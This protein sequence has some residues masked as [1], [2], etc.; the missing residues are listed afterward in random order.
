MSDK[1]T[2]KQQAF[3]LEYLLDFNATAAAER[4]GYR[5]SRQVLA[6][7]GFE[8]LRKEKILQEIWA[9]LLKQA[10][11]AQEVAYRLSRQARGT[12]ADFLSPGPDGRVQIDLPK[13]AAAGALDLVQQLHLDEWEEEDGRLQ[14]NLNLKLYNAQKALQLLGDG[15][16]LWAGKL[17][18]DMTA[19]LDLEEEYPFRHGLSWEE[20]YRDH[21]HAEKSM[22]IWEREHHLHPRGWDIRLEDYGISAIGP[23]EEPPAGLIARDAREEQAWRQRNER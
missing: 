4:A 5:G 6:G 7:I 12:M 2:N 19:S 20:C 11:W 10:M 13:A 21:L 23:G 22:E 16:R 3:I 9:R 14:R 18:E 1:L 15:Y 17:E 8:N